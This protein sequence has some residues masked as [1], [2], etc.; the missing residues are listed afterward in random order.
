MKQLINNYKNGMG[1]KEGFAAAM[2]ISLD[3]YEQR[4]IREVGSNAAP[5]TAPQPTAAPYF[6]VFFLLILVPIIPLLARSR[7]SLPE[8]EIKDE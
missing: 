8:V 5:S 7:H 1:C 3:N 2:G 6:L 4:W